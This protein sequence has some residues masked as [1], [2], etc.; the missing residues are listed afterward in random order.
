MKQRQKAVCA[1]ITRRQNKKIMNEKK[2]SHTVKNRIYMNFFYSPSMNSKLCSP[3]CF[4]VYACRLTFYEK[5][6]EWTNKSGW[7]EH[8]SVLCRPFWVLWIWCVC[9][10]FLLCVTSNKIVLWL[11][12]LSGNSVFNKY[13]RCIVYVRHKQMPSE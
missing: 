7:V 11:E 4:N 12:I 3:H 9:M 1:T 2:D 13:T 10:L 8:V 6:C 5:K